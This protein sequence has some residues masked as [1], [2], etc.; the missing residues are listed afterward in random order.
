MMPDRLEAALRGGARITDRRVRR[1]H[2]LLCEELVLLS[3]SVEVEPAPFDTRLIVN[4]RRFA[5]L[6]PYRDLL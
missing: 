4:G 1:L 5:R 6:A 3:N 2:D